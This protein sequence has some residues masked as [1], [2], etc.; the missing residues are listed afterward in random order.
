MEGDA[1]A[2]GMYLQTLLSWPSAPYREEACIHRKRL[3]R[4]SDDFI[5]IPVHTIPA[6]DE[7]RLY[8]KERWLIDTVREELAQGRGVAVFCRQT[9]TRDIQPRLEKLLKQHLPLCKPFILK[10]SVQADRRE[11][12]LNRQLDLGVNTLICNPKLVQ[13]GLDLVALP[14]IIFFE[15][16]YSLY[17]MGQASRRAWRLIQD[18]PCKVYYP[19]YADLMENQAVELI[20]LKQQAAGLLYGEETG[21]LSTL[22][23]AGGGSLLAELAAEIGADKTIADLGSLFARHAQ[24]SDPTENAWFTEAAAEDVPSQT[25]TEPEPP[26]ILQMEPDVAADP[27]LRFVMELGG[28]ITDV[29]ENRQSAP[30]PPRELVKRRRVKLTDAPEDGPALLLES[31]KSWSRVW[32]PLPAPQNATQL[33]L[34]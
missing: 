30:L 9:G 32:K 7:D 26:V 10:S 12:V 27:L 23:S 16:D 19:F 11:E 5:E 31:S 21:G 13:T 29:Q 3:N 17:V 24:T 1:S 25:K 15:V 6:L 8:A 2:L 28:V 18:K 34:F 14:T 4:D 22:K 33:A 20:G